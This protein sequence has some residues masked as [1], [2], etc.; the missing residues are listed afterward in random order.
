LII[1]TAGEFNSW[2]DV[3]E[4]TLPAAVRTNLT[5]EPLWIPLQH[6]CAEILAPSNRPLLRGQLIEDLK[7]IFLRLHAPRTWE[8]LHGEERAQ[9]RRVLWMMSVVASVFLVLAVAAVRFGIDAQRQSKLAQ[10]RQQQAET[11]RDA[12]T[13]ARLGE[14]EARNVADDN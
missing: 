13:K 1:V 10:Q 3:R 9:R 6:R 5:S 11:A 2:D 12:E 8:E 4:R 14:T 7:Q